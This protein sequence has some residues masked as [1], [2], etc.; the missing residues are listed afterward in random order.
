MAGEIHLADVLDK[1]YFLYEDKKTVVK[2]KQLKAFLDRSKQNLLI[3][4]DLEAY[5]S[6]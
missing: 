5:K 1:L 3:A 6:E 2:N 4:S